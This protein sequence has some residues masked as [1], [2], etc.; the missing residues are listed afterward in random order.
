MLATDSVA[1]FLLEKTNEKQ[2][3]FNTKK[4]VENFQFFTKCDKTFCGIDN[5]HSTMLLVLN[6]W[7]GKTNFLKKRTGSV[8][9]WIS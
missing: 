4:N 9:F 7:S 3:I 5:F 6:I 8:V 1:I 2:K